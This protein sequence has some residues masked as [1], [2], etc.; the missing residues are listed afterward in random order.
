MHFWRNQIINNDIGIRCVSEGQNNLYFG[1]QVAEN[2]YGA[3]V[4]NIWGIGKN[5]VF[6][7]NNFVNNTQN[8]NIDL[9]IV[10]TDHNWTAYHGGSFDNGVRG[11]YWSNYNE[12]DSNRDGFGD[13]PLVIDENRRDNYPLMAPFDISKTEI[14]LPDWA[15]AYSSV[16]FIEPTLSSQISETVE[17]H[18]AFPLTSSLIIVAVGIVA[19]SVSFL[20]FR[21]YRKTAKA[22]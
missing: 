17:P 3:H 8:V 15:K 22:R 7:D 6:Y 9:V 13:L 12:P 14:N 21:K 11:N 19:I 18:P 1:N 16:V 2:N 20:L 10:G 5:N 4:A